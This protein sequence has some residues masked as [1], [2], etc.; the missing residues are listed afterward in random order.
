MGLSIGLVIVAVLLST[1]AFFIVRS[2]K[3]SHL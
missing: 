2:V 1:F 3:K